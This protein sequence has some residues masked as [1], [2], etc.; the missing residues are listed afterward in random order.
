MVGSEDAQ[1]HCMRICLIILFDVSSVRCCTTA[2]AA[3]AVDLIPF[4]G[5]VM[6]FYSG[7]ESIMALLPQGTAVR[8]S[9]MPV[10]DIS[11]EAWDFKNFDG[12]SWQCH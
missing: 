11:M 12:F 4:R 8:A 9:A 1:Q 10:P 2:A 7:L 3:A 5:I 6:D